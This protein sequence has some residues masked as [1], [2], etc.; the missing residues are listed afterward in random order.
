MQTIICIFRYCSLEIT[1]FKIY[2]ASKVHHQ[3]N[4]KKFELSII[5]F[6]FFILFYFQ[7]M[8]LRLSLSIH[9]HKHPHIYTLFTKRYLDS[10]LIALPSNMNIFKPSKKKEMSIFHFLIFLRLYIPIYIYIYI[11]IYIHTY[12]S[13]ED[14]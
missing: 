13:H 2:A 5:H 14:I 10:W 6:N 1:P 12:N 8:F 7:I 11:Y 9:T 4:L 3:S